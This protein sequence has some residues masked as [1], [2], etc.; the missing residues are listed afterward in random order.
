MIL[1]IAGAFDLYRL[2]VEKEPLVGVEPNRANPE[3]DFLAIN[4]NA[5][6]FNY[7]DGA[8]KIWMIN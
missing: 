8:I 3:S 1:M 5:V 4:N 6:A 7:R 2:A